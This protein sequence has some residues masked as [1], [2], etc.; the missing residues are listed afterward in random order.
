MKKQF[1]ITVK[2]IE[3]DNEIVTVKQEVKRWCTS[4]SIRIEPSAPDTQA[5]NGGAERSG[6]VI[7]EKARAIRLDAN[8]PWELWPEITRAAVYLYNRTP[9]YPNKWKSPYE[10]FFTRAAAMNGIVTGPRRPNQ[11]HLRAYGCKAF[12]MTDDTHRGKSRLQR[13]DP[14]AW[15]GYLVGYQSTNIYRIWVPSMAKVISTR[16]VVFDEEAVF[17]GKTEDL[18]DN[19]MHNTLEEIATWVKTIELPGTQSQQPETE[20]FYEDDTVQEETPR[21]QQTRCHRGRKIIEAWP[22]PPP[23]PPPV[24]FLVQEE[25]NNDNKT[26]LSDQATSM[27]VPW[28][29]AFMAGTEAG[30]FGQHEGKPINKA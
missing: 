6:G 17:N 5:Q 16:D 9:N 15:I 4:L 19:L 10:I 11:A 21:R 7:K 3:T 12:A 13:L 28:A 18:M 25:V 26:S 20:T 29:A 8:L 1:N 24:A 23:T 27:T 14:K 2:V 22:T 30:H